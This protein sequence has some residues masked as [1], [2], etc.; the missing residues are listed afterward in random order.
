MEK[1]SFNISLPSLIDLHRCREASAASEIRV[2]GSEVVEENPVNT[3][4]ING[5][6]RGLLARLS[7]MA[8]QP[9]F[10]IILVTLLNDFPLSVL[11]SYVME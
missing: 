5:I 6:N 3:A 1:T 11:Q 4:G 10:L 8:I 7:S 9:E 2:V